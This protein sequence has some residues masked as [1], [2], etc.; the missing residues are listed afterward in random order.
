MDEGYVA[1]LEIKVLMLKYSLEDRKE[2]R[3]QVQEAKK[4]KKG[5]AYQIEMDFIVSSQVRMKQVINL[6][7]ANVGNSLVLFQYVEKHGKVIEKLLKE[8]TSKNIYFISGATKPEERE[9]IRQEMEK[10]SN[11]ILVASYGTCSTGVSIKNIDNVIFASPSK[12]KIKVLQ[13]IGRGLRISKSSSKVMLFDITDDLTYKAVKHSYP[14]YT[15]KHFHERW[16]MYKDEE[17]KVQIYERE[18]K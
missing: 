16:R 2:L 11:I 18:M 6:C 3:K 1:N 5:S 17:F 12:S 4:A 14:N 9:R 10:E 8:H 15:I 7:K 13:S